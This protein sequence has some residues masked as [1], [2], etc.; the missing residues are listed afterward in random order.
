MY[1][2]FVYTANQH[3][4]SSQEKKN[5]STSREF[6]NSVGPQSRHRLVVADP[7]PQSIYIAIHKIVKL[8]V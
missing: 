4:K 2:E 6:P 7:S 1:L 8:W 5:I 3:L